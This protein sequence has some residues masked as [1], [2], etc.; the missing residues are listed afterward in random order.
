MGAPGGPTRTMTARELM[1]RTLGLARRA[2]RRWFP[3]PLDRIL[4]VSGWTQEVQLRHLMRRVRALPDGSRIVELGVWE[5]RSALALAEGE[6]RA[7][8]VG[9]WREREPVPPWAWRRGPAPA[10]AR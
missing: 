10:P 6:A 2:R 3:R 8:R 1:R 4:D 5:G 7:A 9:L